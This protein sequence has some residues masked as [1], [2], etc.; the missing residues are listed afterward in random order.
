MAAEAA[1]LDNPVR[2]ASRVTSTVPDGAKKAAA[3]GRR[4]KVDAYLARARDEFRL[5]ADSESENRREM[6][7]DDRFRAS[8]MWPDDIKRDRLKDGRP[9]LTI[10]RITA[11]IRQLTGEERKSRP[12]IQ[13]NPRG[14]GADRDTA[15]LFE[16]LARAVQNDSHSEIAYDWAYEKAVTIGLGWIRLYTEYESDE[17]FDQVIKID[18][19]ENPFC[20]YADPSATKWDKRDG[21]FLFAKS[22]VP[23]DTFAR[24]YGDDKLKALTEMSSTGD[25]DPNW[26]T[27]TEGCA[28]AEY[29]HEE[30][31]DAEIAQLPDGKVV[32]AADLSP[33]ERAALHPS[34]LR[35][36]QR[37]RIT[38][39]VISGADILEGND[40]LTGGR[41]WMGTFIPFIPIYG[42]VL[43]VD[44]K[45]VYRGLV[46][47]ARDPQ[48]MFNIWESAATE[49]I[50]LAPKAPFIIAAGQIG[51]FGDKWDTANSRNWSY[52]PYE[53]VDSESGHV[54]P[55]PQ[56]NAVEPPIR[57]IMEGLR[58]A[59]LDI[60]ATTGFYDASD[61]HATNADQ[62]GRAILARTQQGSV[63]NIGFL[64]NFERGLTFL[65]E[66][67]VDLA[68]HVYDRPGR[69]L[70]ILGMDDASSLMQLGPVPQAP[71]TSRIAGAVSGFAS[72]MGARMTG[73]PAPQAP[74]GPKVVTLAHGRYNPVV[75]VG[76]SY[77]TKRQETVSTL[78]D[79]FKSFPPAAQVGADILLDNM[80]APGMKQLAERM[81]KMLPPQLQDPA[82]G[83]EPIP[84]HAQQQIAQMQ[85]ALQ[86]L[87]QQHAQA[88]EIIRTKKVESDARERIAAGNNQATIAVAEAR[89]GSEA[90]KLALGQAFAKFTQEVE[91]LHQRMLSEA[92]GTQDAVMAGADAAHERAMSAQTAGQDQAAAAQGAG[93]DAAAAGQQQGADAAAQAS[94]Q[95]HQTAQSASDQTH[96][97][98]MADRTAGHA[99]DAAKAAAATAVKMAALKPKPGG[100]TK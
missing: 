86:E 46:R 25:S 66:Q 94:D 71:V 9:C 2:F 78:L 39:A 77:A 42:E 74:A 5:S 41:V 50:A 79:L 98:S 64:D 38:Q 85:Q 12:S 17:S 13:I 73:Q 54:L 10:D 75:T 19:V 55:M 24:K 15:D 49:M 63:S 90:N 95:A 33:K 93:A 65:A 52:L 69:I 32:D 21:R 51:K 7:E 68:P 70:Q 48:R 58:Q 31:V 57:A 34:Q 18:W 4:A 53:P 88:V 91:L 89:F 8:D 87:Q 16:G 30:F 56:R 59:D 40:D 36:V 43:N 11:P 1:T 47:T 60:R 99:A 23:A 45:R 28:V 62:S 82:E 22:W 83:E 97:A 96:Q 20:I 84:A 14:G 27:E 61:P 67:F 80:D 72:R 44:G 76:A 37:R 29:W 26:Y 100:G 92:E 81:K 3:T 35:Q 6:L